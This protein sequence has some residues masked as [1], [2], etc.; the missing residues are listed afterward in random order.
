[1]GETR[2]DKPKKNDSRV[3]IFKGQHINKLIENKQQHKIDK[4]IGSGPK[5]MKVLHTLE[6]HE[7]IISCLAWSNDGTLLASGSNDKTIRIWNWREGKN[8]HTLQGHEDSIKCLAWSPDGCYLAS[9]SNDNTIRVWDVSKAKL[10]KLLLGHSK[11]VYSL[12]WSP[13][14]KSLGSSSKDRTVRLWDIDEGRL[15]KLFRVREDSVYSMT[16]SDDGHFIVALACDKTIRH[17]NMSKR[18][19]VHVLH[20]HEDRI[21]SMTRSPDNAWIASASDDKT[22]RIWNC[23]LE[24]MEAVLEGHTNTVRSV[25]FSS[26]STILASQSTD[27]TIRLWR[28]DTWQEIFQFANII[29][30]KLPSFVFHPHAANI[31]AMRAPSDSSQLDSSIIL[32][33]LESAYLLGQT[34]DDKSGYYR[35][36]KVVLVG[37]TGVGKSG[38]ALVLTN[39]PYK[40]TDSSDGRHVWKFDENQIA[41]THHLKETRETLLWDLAGQPGYRL[42]HQMHL[43]EVAVA[44]IV[45]DARSETNP[46]VGIRHWHRAL[47]QAQRRQAKKS[48]P[49]KRFLVLARSDRDGVAISQERIDDLVRKMGLDGYYE[50]SAREGWGIDE[51]RKAIIEAIDWS[52]LPKVISTELFQCIKH[53]VLDKKNSGQLICTKNQ[54]YQEFIKAYPQPIAE[55]LRAAFETCL[56]RLQHRDLVRCMSFGNYLLLQPE[57]LDAYAS[58]MINAAKREPDAM[59]SLFEEDALAGRF[60]MAKDVRIKDK[61]HEELILIATVKELVD[62]DLALREKAGN[63]HWLVF[64]SQTVRD[65]PDAPD[66]KGKAVEIRFKGA[67]RNIYAT[68][69]VRLANSHLFITGR[70]EMW[71]NAA[72]YEACSGGYCGI[73]LREFEEGEGELILFYDSKVDSKTRTLFEDYVSAHLEQ[74]AIPETVRKIRLYVCS[75]CGEP[76]PRR[77]AEGTKNRQKMWITCGVCGGEVKLLEDQG[78]SDSE[79]TL[80]YSQVDNMN[81]LADAQ[82]QSNS[83]AMTLQGKIK[84]QDYDVFLCYNK[85]DSQQVKKIGEQLK[86]KGILP[87][88]DDWNLTPGQNWCEEI[89]GQ[90]ENIKSAAVFVGANGIGP[91]QKVELHAILHELFNRKRPIIP[92]LLSEIDNLPKLPLFLKDFTWVNFCKKDPDPIERLILGIT[93]GRKD[94]DC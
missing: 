80:L 81:E 38:L 84:S 41:I 91:W 63:G 72:R 65:W 31:L 10:K 13:D 68:L 64:P 35:N 62:Y 18:E 15:H 32:W 11:T 82:R 20:G 30:E 8:V 49:I 36:A 73:Y 56:T 87:W 59:G 86:Q 71:H 23:S 28:T 76:V 45:F 51:L 46:L 47:L 43:N 66:P 25:G 9:G 83:Y 40:A 12:A 92:V 79:A 93:G 57:L 61:S 17:W 53:F 50:T 4:Q 90:I 52:I 54:L 26:D 89:E 27:N 69:I 29:S 3:Q 67:V 14:G 85:S 42:I 58:A 74:R 78:Q 48:I 70:E 2:V 24:R 6:G 16:W 37:D 55:D 94:K 33:D 75:R 44:L 77:Y 60:Q 88:L 21:N 5:G 39:R 7:G 34:A 22:V 19:L 1:M